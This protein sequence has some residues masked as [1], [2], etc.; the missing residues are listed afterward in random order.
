MLHGLCRRQIISTRISRDQAQ[1]HRPSSVDV[2]EARTQRLTWNTC[3]C[4]NVI[5]SAVHLVSIPGVYFNAQRNEL[6][7]PE[8]LSPCVL[9]GR[10]LVYTKMSYLYGGSHWD[11]EV[12]SVYVMPNKNTVINHKRQ[13]LD[14]KN[15]L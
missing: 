5:S 6:C 2:L 12:Y 7:L 4:S 8:C 1:P 9:L 13:K 14:L 15:N 10:D 11:S 3:S